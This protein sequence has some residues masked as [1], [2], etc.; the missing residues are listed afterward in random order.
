MSRAFFNLFV[1]NLVA[2]PNKYINNL[3][4][5]W[6][7]CFKSCCFSKYIYINNLGKIFSGLKVMYIMVWIGLIQINEPMSLSHW[8]KSNH[9]T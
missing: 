9:K 2:F 7:I 8:L 1:L 4:K 6:F 3:G 5:I